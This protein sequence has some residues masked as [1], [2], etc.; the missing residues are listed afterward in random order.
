M[1]DEMTAPGSLLAFFQCPWLT[2]SNTK[3][4]SPTMNISAHSKKVLFLS[5]LD[6]TW[7]SKNPANRKALDE[8]VQELRDEYASKGIELEFGYVTARPPERVAQE[9][10][11]TPDWTITFNGGRIDKGTGF[12]VNEKGEKVKAE[13]WA[14]WNEF[15]DISRF[16]AP[17]AIEEAKEVL[18]RGE[19]GTMTL[20]TIGEVVQN[21]AADDCKFATH[22]C[23]P[24][25]NVSLTEA[26]KADENHD[27]T[28][29]IL[30]P[31]TFMPPEQL[32]NFSTTLNME[33]KETGVEYEISR[34]YL[35]QGKPYAMLDIASPLANKGEAVDY[36]RDQE[37][38]TRDHLIIAG[39]GGNDISM[40]RDPLGRDDGRR[41]IVVGPDAGLRKAGSGLSHAI[42][43]DPDGDCSLGVLNGLRRHLEAIAAE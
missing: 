34:P 5:D 14:N 11:P 36:L 9:N 26:E 30:Q 6:G 22:L 40:M 33:L 20:N 18:S 38:V 28:P 27:G 10:L 13:A 39:D 29:D 19:F 2:C 25:N 12:T 43:Q 35:F 24:L 1:K 21:P 7:L 16:S 42:L 37:G 8:G 15:N 3:R 23:F 31:A 4:K 41:V 32:L 17:L